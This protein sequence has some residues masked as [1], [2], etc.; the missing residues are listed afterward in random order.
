M[1]RSEEESQARFS[2]GLEQ[3]KGFCIITTMK[4]LAIFMVIWGSGIGAI[5]WLIWEVIGPLSVKALD[6]R[7]E[8][9]AR[10]VS[11]NYWLAVPFWFIASAIGVWFYSEFIERIDMGEYPE[12]T[13]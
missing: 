4:G 2:T 10:Q 8:P 12:L 11:G 7:L 5:T 1:E 6:P 13:K 3:E 9:Y